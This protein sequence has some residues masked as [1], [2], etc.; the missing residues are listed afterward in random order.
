MSTNKQHQVRSPFSKRL[1]MGVIIILLSVVWFYGNIA[2]Q[3][4]LGQQALEQTGLELLTLEQAL[5]VAKGSNKLVLTNMSAIWCSSCRKLDKQVFADERVKT[6]LNQNFVYAHIDYDS[7][8]G[9]SFMQKYH[10][11]GF[12]TL[13][14]FNTKGEKL[15]QLPIK[16]EPITFLVSLQKVVEASR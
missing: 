6:K 9:Q 7:P 13:L 1:R 12:P 4:Y 3:S 14:I 11:T 5:K 2:L 8:A 15:V 16:Y 10:V